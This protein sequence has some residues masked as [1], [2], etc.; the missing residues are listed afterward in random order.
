MAT[1]AIW[2]VRD[3]LKRVLD[4][5]ANPHKTTYIDFSEY[6]FQGLDNV[7][8]Y[9]TQDIK[10]E[11]QL[12]VS[13][14]N[15]EPETVCSEMIS[16]KIRFQKEDG[17]LAYHAYQS[18]APNEVNAETAH[19][20]G[21]E[22]AQAMWGDRFE[23]QVSTHLDKEHFHNHFVINSVSFVDGKRYKDN[24][25]NYRLMRNLSDNLCKKYDLSVIKN[26]RRNSLH[27][28]EWQA[29]KKHRPTERSLICD[30][31]DFAISQSMTYTQFLNKLKEMGYKV[32]TNVK[33]TAVCP[34]GKSNY[35]RLYK[36]KD[37]GSY[38]EEHIKARILENKNVRY[39]SIQP[40][41]TV[42]HF[43]L[44][45]DLNKQHKL[46][47]FR[48]LYFKYMYMM[49]I[50]P[51]NNPHP[52]RVHFL[53]REDIR[54]MDHISKEAILL[55][56]QKIDTI[57]QLDYKENM[58]KYQLDSYIK[59][60]RCL[61]NKKKRC[62]NLETKKMLLKDIESLSKDIKQ[63]REEVKLYESIRIRSVTM[64]DKLH[65]ICVEEHQQQK[66][67]LKKDERLKQV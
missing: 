50:L 32:K 51:K 12:Y 44:K 31:I 52:K 64:K 27:Y 60:R 59:E 4:Y 23:V 38:D 57:D 28:A 45:G 26:P 46:T 19:Q 36:L 9:T 10:T 30:D 3:N 8:E 34:P 62:R 22:F 16:T 67:T 53:L 29:N 56:K 11:K 1:T 25:A 66:Q 13:C 24:K 33:Y 63:L 58:T 2:D 43:V 5:C 48:A 39:E 42:K 55:C 21:I 20:I 49:G 54:Y 18:F 41:L 6:T 7:L 40:T 35:F 17:I 47:G 15:C 61:Y 14:L 65:S 37:D